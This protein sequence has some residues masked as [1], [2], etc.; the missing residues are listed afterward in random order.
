MEKII[1]Q[2]SGLFWSIFNSLRSGHLKEGG[3]RFSGY[4]RDTRQELG[5]LRAAWLAATDGASCDKTPAS[6]ADA[7]P[8]SD[9][10]LFLPSSLALCWSSDNYENFTAVF[11]QCTKKRKKTA[12]E[13]HKWRGRSSWGQTAFVYLLAHESIWLFLHRKTWLSWRVSIYLSHLE[14]G[15]V[16]KV[17]A[18]SLALACE[19][20]LNEVDDSDAIWQI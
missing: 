14:P 11:P 20:P 3:G 15:C 9:P 16:G 6:V 13:V 5:G 7:P 4:L 12:E 2:F 19:G 10:P 17:A 1:T 8:S 18:D